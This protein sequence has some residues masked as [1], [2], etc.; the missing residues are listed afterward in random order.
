LLSLPRIFGT[1]PDNIPQEI[2]YLHPILAEH[3]LPAAPGQLKVGLAWAGNPGHFNDAARSLRLTDLSPLLESPGIAFFSLQVPVPPQDEPRLR[4][5]PGLVDLSP[6][7]TDF[8][9]TAAFIAQM[10]LVIT[11]DTAVAHLAGALG[12]PVWSLLQHAP[13]WRW[14][15]ERTDTPWYPAMRL[16]RQPKLGD[17]LSPVRQAANELN[18]LQRSRPAPAVPPAPAR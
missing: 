9:R 7:L 13:D 3:P 10:D 12:K 16:F 2:P 1:R 14:L 17:W 11:A 5:C 15:L 4:S 8:R 18:S 6:Q